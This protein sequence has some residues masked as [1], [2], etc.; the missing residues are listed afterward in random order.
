MGG[1]SPAHAALAMS[2]GSEVLSDSTAAYDRGE[3]SV[4]RG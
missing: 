2:I 4:L 3:N 1:G